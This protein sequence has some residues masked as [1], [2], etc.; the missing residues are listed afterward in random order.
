MR[1]ISVLTIVG[2]FALSIAIAGCGHLKKQ[3]FE[4]RVSAYQ[5]AQEQ[6]NTETNTKITTL[7]QKVDQQGSEL[8]VAVDAAQKSADEAKAMAEQGDVDTLE[9]AKAEDEKVR[10]AAKQLAQEAGNKAQQFAKEEDDKIRQEARRLANAAQNRANSAAD[11]A[12]KAT[13]AVA[14]MRGQVDDLVKAKP[15]LAAVVNFRSGSS[16]LNAK[17]KETLDKA[18]DKINMYGGALIKVKG[19]ADGNPVLGGKYG[20]NWELSEARAKAVIKYLEGKG[21]TNTME[22]IARAHTE[23]IAPAFTKAG[24]AENRRAE[25]IIYQS[26]SEM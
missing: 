7:E 10:Q 22:A 11:A 5:G 2:I 9:A 12:E 18:V 23:P 25:V 1:K 6:I 17:A 14:Q 15:I 13:S 20:S 4:K 24:R 8:K 26:G 19:H 16:A 21:V 3:E